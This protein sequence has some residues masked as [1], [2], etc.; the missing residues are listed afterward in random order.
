MLRAGTELGEGGGAEGWP[1][2]LSSGDE[3]DRI[4]H[5]RWAPAGGQLSAAS[6]LLPAAGKAAPPRG[7]AER[8]SPQNQPSHGSSGLSSDT[9]GPE[10]DAGNMV[11]SA[12]TSRDLLPRLSYL[13]SAAVTAPRCLSSQRTLW[14]SRTAGKPYGMA[15]EQ[16]RA[17]SGCPWYV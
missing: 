9:G 3:E 15:G 4:H 5:S 6:T 2:D 1:A 14:R 10:P 12:E 11:L 17:V 7:Q 8:P 13:N 16:G